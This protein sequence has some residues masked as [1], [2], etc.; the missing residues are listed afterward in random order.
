MTGRTFCLLHGAECDG[1]DDVA[2]PDPAG[3]CLL[4]EARLEQWADLCDTCN[5]AFHFLAV[6]LELLGG[7][8]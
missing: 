1:R 3:L 5:A 8:Q 7:V 6:G 2:Q 4:C